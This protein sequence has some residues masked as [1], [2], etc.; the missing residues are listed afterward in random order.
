MVENCRVRCE[1]RQRQVGNVPPQSAAGQQVT[2]DVVEPNTLSEFV[3]LLRCLHRFT[4]ASPPHSFESWGCLKQAAQT[5]P[6]RAQVM[7]MSKKDSPIFQLLP[8]VA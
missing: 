6:V 8:R 5:N 3:Q 2:G 4:S 7:Q 1:S